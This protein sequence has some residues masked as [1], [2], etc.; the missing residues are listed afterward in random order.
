MN[1]DVEMGRT[2]EEKKQMIDE[3]C[4][5]FTKAFETLTKAEKLFLSC[6]INFC[7]GFNNKPIADWNESGSNAHIY[8][9]GNKFCKLAEIEPSAI[10]NDK[11]RRYIDYK[12]NPFPVQLGRSKKDKC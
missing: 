9:G 5:L 12:G 6:G 8:S 11:D 1:G 3:G 2:I 4:E 10:R 7:G